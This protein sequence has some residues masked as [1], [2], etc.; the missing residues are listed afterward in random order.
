M[1]DDEQEMYFEVIKT[2]PTPFDRYV[3][4]GDIEDVVDI[5]GPRMEV[6]RGAIRAVRFT[7][8]DQSARFVPII[9]SAGSG[10]THFYWVLKSKD[11]A[12]EDMNYITVYVPS[13][14][15]PT[16][17]LLH[18]YTALMDEVGIEILNIVAK[19]VLIDFGAM[20]R[21]KRG[22]S[23]VSAE[24]VARTAMRFYPGL[25][26]DVL[27][28][29][30]LFGMGKKT[31][32]HQEAEIAEAWLLGEAISEEEMD[33]I[34]VK[35]LIEDDD[36]C[37]AAIKLFVENMDRP[38]VLYFDEL[39]IPFRMFGEDAEIRIWE[40]MKRLYNELQN[41]VIVAS[42]LLEV[43]DKIES[44][45]DSAMR[46][47]MET[48][49]RLY[50]FKVEDIKEFY[51][52]A[53]SHFWDV[54]NLPDPENKFFPLEEF[55]FDKIY[56][57]SKGNPRDSI[58][59][60]RKAID[61]KIDPYIEHDLTLP[62]AERVIPPEQV[63]APVTETV[64]IT[65]AEEALALA[66]AETNTTVT[67]EV[68]KEVTPSVELAEILAIDVNPGSIVGGALCSVQAIARNLGKLN[69]ISLDLDFE[70]RTEKKKQKLGGTVKRGPNM[71]IGVEVPSVKSFDKPG[72]VAAYYAIRRVH[73]ALKNGVITKGC[74]I[75]PTGTK[76]NKY[77]QVRESAGN[78]IMIIEL[79][80]EE[81]EDLIRKC[82]EKPITQL[83]PLIKLLFPDYEPE[84]EAEPEPEVRPYSE[85]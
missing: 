1:D 34:G 17:I 75:T 61:E 16:R 76:G 30:I 57:R 13:P 6:E 62:E 56:H 35:S 4:R 37:L 54:N 36:V 14:P 50:P 27:K 29:L 47:R 33:K 81:A 12:P 79:N 23:Y 15:S 24:Q 83:T 46:S 39:E 11:I 18:V 21:M 84:P 7:M 25:N 72:G 31:G 68:G 9:G 64:K 55:V 53:M 48:T 22:F 28:S 80:Q 74:L 65:T 41:V 19:K 20:E 77:T 52:R 2:T 40:T 67:Q 59:L 73:D 32:Q 44:L 70:F 63:E 5:P 42:C 82:Q 43:W 51:V 26:V 10:K 69:E 60:T 78:N 71:L 66:R 58:K 8:S 85:S 3:S 49:L 38:I 45:A